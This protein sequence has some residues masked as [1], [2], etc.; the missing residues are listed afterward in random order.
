MRNGIVAVEIG[1][2]GAVSLTRLVTGHR[3]ADVIS[4][5]D[6]RDLGD[7]YTPS[8]RGE[9]RT[10]MRAAVHCEYAG[11]LR[12]EFVVRWWLG[13]DVQIDVHLTLDAGAPF[14]RLRVVGENRATD[15]RLRVA[16]RTDVASPTVSADAAFGLV[17]RKR[18]DIAPAEAAVEQAPLTA[19]LHRYVSL[20]GDGRG[21]TIFSD[22][23][24]EYEARDDGTV[25][26]TLLRA[27]GELSRN[28]LP[29]RPGHAGWPT[30]TPGAQCLGAFD[31]ML[32]IMPH[33]PRGTNM[34]EAV[35]RAADDV[36]LP[37]TGT[38]IR[39]MLDIPAARFG[40]EL[41]GAGLSA[42]TIKESEDGQWIVLRC[43]NLLDTP[44]TG[45]WRLGVKIDEACVARLDETPGEA[46]AVNAGVV[47]FTVPAHG[48][49]TVLVR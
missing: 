8:P 36:L 22:G 6:E 27:V 49:S 28:D 38:T 42:S 18:I 24:A 41:S 47:T 45:T 35:E 11:P 4:F 37:L 40:A 39:S 17:Q 20:W 33:G 48:V 1:D 23:L 34:I 32:A 46:L 14:L 2:N 30:P 3:V 19:P 29:E 16:L 13:D 26:V 10:P 25:L 9:I 31:A 43:V 44:V 21:A 15:H 7:L 12:G 5:V